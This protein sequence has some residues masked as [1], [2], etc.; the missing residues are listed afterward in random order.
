MLLGCCHRARMKAIVN[1]R[2]RR[3]I[4]PAPWRNLDWRVCGSKLA[5]K[6]GVRSLVA[7]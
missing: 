1:Y 3:V 6:L 7:I 5:E 4:T 2:A